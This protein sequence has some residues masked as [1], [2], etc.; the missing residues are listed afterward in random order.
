[1]EPPTLPDLL[2][3]VCP[4]V[5][6]TG[7]T[8][9]TVPSGDAWDFFNNEDMPDNVRYEMIEPP[10]P[11]RQPLL[12]SVVARPGLST[13]RPI[14]SSDLE[15][16]LLT[17][18]EEL[19]KEDGKNITEEPN[20]A[21]REE[22]E[23]PKPPLPLNSQPQK[24][25]QQPQSRSQSQQQQQQKQKQQKQLPQQS[26]QPQ[27]QKQEE[28]KEQDK[29]QPP[30]SDP[31]PAVLKQRER[32][33]EELSA[34]IERL[35]AAVKRRVDE[36][37]TSLE[38]VIKGGMVQG[39]VNRSFELMKGQEDEREGERRRQQQDSKVEAASKRLEQAINGC[40]RVLETAEEAMHGASAGLTGLAMAVESR[41]QGEA[42]ERRRIV[43]ARRIATLVRQTEAAKSRP[44]P[45]SAPA[46][47]PALAPVSAPSAVPNAV[48]VSYDRERDAATASRLA[49]TRAMS[50]V[51]QDPK[52]P[53]Q[54]VGAC[55]DEALRK[56][57]DEADIIVG[58]C[59]DRFMR[60]FTLCDKALLR[61][62]LDVFAQGRDANISSEVAYRLHGL[63]MGLLC[64]RG[65]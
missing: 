52:F 26:S 36:H 47:G 65:I 12:N 19:N 27:L 18:Q 37:R 6:T 50:R 39:L 2:R 3:N 24:Q 40:A 10:T 58:A 49:S 14:S 45:V 42:L 31:S 44:C 4:T 28:T 59:I 41:A 23:M 15:R 57:K 48:P 53:F 63:T 35:R 54:S 46:P 22:Q 8:T 29:I 7:P 38:S 64:P 62:F 1:M 51:V 20:P 34:E 55:F 17:E 30:T 33:I 25:S 16:M 13:T 5:P 9:I 60:N 11:P 43:L 61:Q 56:E 21:P 32:E